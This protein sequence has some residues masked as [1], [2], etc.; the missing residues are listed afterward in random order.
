MKSSYYKNTSSFRDP[1][2]FI[3]SSNNK[4]YRVINHSY[5]E[6]YETLVKS[7]LLKKLI[8]L[9][10]LVP[11]KEVKNTFIIDKNIFK[12]LKP[13][14]VKFISYPYE[15]SF[16]QLKDAALATL[17]I[18]KI[19]LAH[20]MTLK[21]ASAFNI[22]F[23]QGKPVLI[24]FLSFEK[25]VENEPWTAYKQFCQHFLGPL[26]LISYKD[27]KLNSLST[28]YV[29]GIPLDLI[30]KLL[31][32]KTYL[33]FSLLTH[34]HIHSKFQ[35]SYSDN[36]KKINKKNNLS[37]QNLLI[38][39]EA[40]ESAI[41]SIKWLPENTEWAN[42]YNET[43][44]SKTS[45]TKKKKIVL[46][47]LNKIGHNKVIWDLGANDGTFGR[48]G[49]KTNALS[50][51]SFDM[52]PAAV[53]INYLKC[54]RNNE[55]NHLP[56]IIDLA[57]PTPSIGWENSE[58]LSFMDRAQSDIVIALALIHHLAIS[59]NLGFDL[60]ASF[61]SKICKNLIIEFIPKEDS[62]VQR[63]LVFRKDIFSEYNEKIFI[64]S[65]SKYF[66]I[67]ERDE[68]KGSKRILFRMLKK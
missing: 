36:T 65:F 42:Y 11:H 62:N 67:K 9:N 12:I 53:E 19:A 21:D 52:D 13:S 35:N 57:N 20:N 26:A 58:R 40:L 33:N 46:N 16:S 28:N 1:D 31:P 30:S 49:L 34:I 59:N 47:Y 14:V 43:N 10:L 17:Q 54:K 7:G 56:L 32:L 27:P 39:I 45:F 18:E 60:L 55:T 3:F 4:I 22:Q 63:L 25:Y 51:F 6:N 68:I 8:N 23:Y 37:K 64:N 38:F 24:D 48:L 50:V 2:G 44:Y 41:R 5:K 29:D 61:F 66:Y 15:W